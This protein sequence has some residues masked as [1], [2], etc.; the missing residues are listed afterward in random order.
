[1]LHVVKLRFFVVGG[2][3]QIGRIVA[4]FVALGVSRVVLAC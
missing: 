4:V 3:A 1:M 2:G